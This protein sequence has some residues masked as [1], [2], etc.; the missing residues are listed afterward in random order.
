MFPNSKSSAITAFIIALL[1]FIENHSKI[2]YKYAVKVMVPILAIFILYFI[3]KAIGIYTVGQGAATISIFSNRF[4]LAAIALKMYPPKLFGQYVDTIGT[5]VFWN[6]NALYQ[7]PVLLSDSVSS[8]FVS[9]DTV[10]DV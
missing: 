3:N 2:V 6:G 5:N 7:N 8:I 1:F 10:S 4:D 9:A